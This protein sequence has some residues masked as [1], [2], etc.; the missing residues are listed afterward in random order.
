[1]Y[2]TSMKYMRHLYDRTKREYR[3]QAETQ[4]EFSKWKERTRK[5]LKEIIG[6]ER[7]TY[8]DEERAELHIE[9]DKGKFIQQYWTLQT[10]PDVYV[11]FYVL[12]P[13]TDG[14]H[15]LILNPHGHGGGKEKTLGD[16][17]RADVRERYREGDKTFAVT[18]AEKGYVVVCP[19]AR[20]SGERREKNQ[21]GDTLNKQQENSHLELLKIGIG[22]GI[23]PIGWL[24]WDLMRLLDFVERQPFVDSDRIAVVGMSGGGHQSLW[25]G[26]LDDRI[27]VIVTSGYFY[28]MKEALLEMPE[29][30][31]CNYVPYIWETV[32][33]GDIGALLAPRPFLVESG[34]YDLLNGK[35]GIENVNSQIDI[36]RR[37]YQLFG[38]EDFLMHSVHGGGHV[39]TGTDVVPFV[40]NNL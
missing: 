27:K 2:Y 18:M 6:L 36:A 4:E 10:E 16:L 9:E 40:E 5:R 39:W 7:C 14:R 25:L 19:D 28:G 29:N 13:K 37:A 38:K 17:S 32:D 31:P 8:A 11:P 26:A 24:V 30:C 15:P 35:S 1:M 3:F 20:G 33:M 22:F 21:Q 23:A 34:I 12:K